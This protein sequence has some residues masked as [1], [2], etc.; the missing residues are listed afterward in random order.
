MCKDLKKIFNKANDKFLLK[1]K[2]MIYDDVA[3][4]SLCSEFKIFLLEELN[5]TKYSQYHI[6]ND[7]NR[8]CGKIK[9][10]INGE[11][12]EINIQ[13]D[14]IIHSR[15]ENEL[16]DN[17]LALEMKK[18]YRTEK[19]KN[20]DRDRLCALTKD[21]HDEETYSYDGKTF[22]KHVCG[23]QLGVY[24]EIDIDEKKVLIEYYQ[25]GVLIEKYEKEIE[26]AGKKRIA[27]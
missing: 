21:K 22:P 1:S 9:T 7:Y 26:N 2:R 20:S 14:L 18:S 10:T 16:R 8:N 27:Y 3:E 13:C 25:K 12:K 23:Y 24:Y 4:R 5:K 6:D 15:G 11:M 17:L 19:E